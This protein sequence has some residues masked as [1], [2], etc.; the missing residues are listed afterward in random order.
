M[1]VV[2][3]KG[4][5]AEPAP[6]FT[7]S[8]LSLL[9]AEKYEAELRYVDSWSRWMRWDGCAW[10]HETTRLAAD[11]VHKICRES[12]MEYARVTNGKAPRS[13]A[14][15]TTV[16]GV[17][18]LARGDRRMAA[19]VDQWDP[20]DWLL[21]T[22]GG[23]VDLRTGE[24]RS[25]LPGDYMTKTTG[26]NPDGACGID[27]WLS[28]LRTSMGGD[29]EMVG[30]LQ[31]LFGYCLTGSTREETLHFFHGA[32]AN[33]K[34]KIIDA[35]SR[36]IG[37]YQTT[38]PMETF[39]LSK[40]QR[41]PTEIADLCGARMVT[42]VETDEGR[43]W[44]EA[45][46]KALTGGDEM[47]ARRMREDFWSFRPKF[48][49]VIHGNHKPMLRMIDEAIR[50]R[51]H[52]VPFNVIVPKEDRDQQLGEK[53]RAEWPGILAWMI[54]GCALWQERGLDPPA[55]IVEA[56]KEYLDSQ[57]AVERWIDEECD[58]DKGST[59]LR[60]ALFAS[61]S[62]WADQAKEYVIKQAAFY[63][64]LDRKGYRPGKS[65][66]QRTFTGLRIKRNIAR[67]AE[68]LTEDEGRR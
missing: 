48:T 7:E 50:R 6:Q 1:T 25:A 28:V 35:V 14:G 18:S 26:V 59:E 53:L 52:L 67:M 19:T 61:W 10:R 44:D 60:S 4:E 63:E 65:S 39:L 36:C 23:I 54:R 21:N 37:D 32:G 51:M 64:V 56:T 66:G 43:S 27:L 29:E 46:I 62:A 31:R 57:D 34:T 30:Y 8:A 58:K 41:H 42:A 47:K 13:L 12:A 3:F 2:P 33:G 49:P 5:D 15:W 17:E 38:T 16:V 68:K 11:Y 55:T 9:F 22:P 24:P 45:K 40:Y 20:D